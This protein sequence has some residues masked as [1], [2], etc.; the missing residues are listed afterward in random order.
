MKFPVTTWWQNVTWFSPKTNSLLTWTKTWLECN[1]NSDWVFYFPFLFFYFHHD[2]MSCTNWF[3]VSILFFFCCVISTKTREVHRH[4]HRHYYPEESEE[5][6][7][8]DCHHEFR[9]SLQN[10]M[11]VIQSSLLP[12]PF[13]P[14]KESCSIDVSSKSY[15]GSKYKISYYFNRLIFH[16]NDAFIRIKNGRKS[17]TIDRDRG[18]FIHDKH[19]SII[20]VHPNNETFIM[21]ELSDGFLSHNNTFEMVFTAFTG[22][23]NDSWKPQI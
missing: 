10:P 14:Q 6:S 17:Q 7:Q 13:H 1:K 21:I 19:E 3:H 11:V 12:H 22:W 20:T 9:I 2:I 23:W 5:G 8:V 18:S 4:R 15:L 16:S